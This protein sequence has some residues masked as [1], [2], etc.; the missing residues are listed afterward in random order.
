[1]A[2]AAGD[3]ATSVLDP[4]GVFKCPSFSGNRGDFEGWVFR[5]ESYCGMLGWTRYVETV[6]T[7]REEVDEDEQVTGENQV[8]VSRQLYHLLVT[9]CGGPALSLIRLTP[10]GHGFEA[11]RRLY[12]EYRPELEEDHASHLAAIL[13]PTWWAE[14][15]DTSFVHVL[16]KWDEL[17]AD[18]QMA[19]GEEITDKMRT[20]TVIAH[21]P[22]EIRTFVHSLA[23]READ[24]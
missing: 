13:T 5:F 9:C 6:R 7:L 23:R 15:R 16:L 24:E 14:H 4:R 18:Y 19:T 1:M 11:L 12:W 10:R 17:I 8:A 20:A 21:A 3:V 2:A 22:A